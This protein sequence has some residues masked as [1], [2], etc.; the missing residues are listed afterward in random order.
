MI[1]IKLKSHNLFIYLRYVKELKLTPRKLILNLSCI[2]RHSTCAERLPKNIL[3]HNFQT[4]LVNKSTYKI[5]KG[6]IFR[7]Q[8]LLL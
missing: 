4:D 8:V 6:P 2:L 3:I 5:L 7:S 1:K